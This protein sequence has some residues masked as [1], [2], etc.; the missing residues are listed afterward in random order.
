MADPVSEPQRSHGLDGNLRGLIVLG[1][2]VVAGF[3]LLAKA[4]NGNA[5][6]VTTTG[7]ATTT[8]VPSAGGGATNGTTGGAT[9]SSVPKSTT[10]T[11]ASGGAVTGTTRTPASVSVVV[12]NGSGGKKG[13]ASGATDKIKAKGYKTLQPGNAAPVDKTIMYYANGFQADAVAVAGVLGQ[14]AS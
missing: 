9:S 2:A 10:T 4:D 14:P 13:V 5:E 7:S 3:F 11:A 6:S 12:L 1:L 8:T